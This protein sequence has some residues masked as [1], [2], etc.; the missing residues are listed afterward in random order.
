MHTRMHEETETRGT[1]ALPVRSPGL[2]SAGHT[3]Q[4]T[5][6]VPSARPGGGVSFVIRDE[7]SSAS[8]CA[9]GGESTRVR[10]QTRQQTRLQATSTHLFSLFLLFSPPPNLLAGTG[11]V[12]LVRPRTT[13]GEETCPGSLVVGTCEP[14]QRWP[15]AQQSPGLAAVVGPGAQAT[16]CAHTQLSNG[17]FVPV[18]FFSTRHFSGALPRWRPPFTPTGRQ[19]P[20]EQTPRRPHTWSNGRTRRASSTTKRPRT[21]LPG[22]CFASKQNASVFVDSPRAHDGSTSEAVPAMNGGDSI[23][24][25]PG[26]RPGRTAESTGWRTYVAN[27]KTHTHLH[28]LSAHVSARWKGRDVQGSPVRCRIDCL[29]RDAACCPRLGAAGCSADPAARHQTTV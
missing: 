9:S 18:A 14:G 28:G 21:R 24:A 26:A 4:P 27:A 7:L 19:G 20:R 5:P 3:R 23:R 2:R 11:S 29:S 8:D 10:Q 13:G 25:W 12:E 17:F 16:S 1:F 6:C 22:G 15:D